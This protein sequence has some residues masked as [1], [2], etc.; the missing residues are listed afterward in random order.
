VESRPGEVPD[1]GLDSDGDS[2]AAVDSDVVG[3]GSV[4]GRSK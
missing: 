4:F 2:G 3:F 1:D